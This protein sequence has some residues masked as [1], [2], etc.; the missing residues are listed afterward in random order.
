[1]LN[2]IIGTL[3]IGTLLNGMTIMDVSYSV[4]N[5]VKGMVLLVAILVDSLINPR[6]EETA[7]QGDI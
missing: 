2:V 4:Q 6:N 1:V 7:Q 3:L 5:I